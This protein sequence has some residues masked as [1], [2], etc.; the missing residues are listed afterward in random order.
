MAGA[1]RG[2]TP[3]PA[4]HATEFDTASGEAIG[5]S[6]FA[7]AGAGIVKVLILPIVADGEQS[8][9]HDRWLDPSVAEFSTVAGSSWTVGAVTYFG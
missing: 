3:E 7:D 6:L 5:M 2:A 1:S 8:P 9:G 4:R